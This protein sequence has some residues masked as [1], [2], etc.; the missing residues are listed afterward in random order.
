MKV[1]KRYFEWFRKDTRPPYTLELLRVYRF[2]VI[3]HQNWTISIDSAVLDNL[4]ANIY[5]VMPEFTLALYNKFLKTGNTQWP[6][7][8]WWLKPGFGAEKKCPTEK[9]SLVDLFK[10]EYEVYY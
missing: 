4:K 7:F 5:Y 10:L 6:V 9:M 1:D 8:L 2:R 3:G